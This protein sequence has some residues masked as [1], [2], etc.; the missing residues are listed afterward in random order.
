V[1]DPVDWPTRDLLTHRAAAT[2]ERTALVDA[3]AGRSWTYR[4]LSDRVDR[5]AADLVPPAA[6]RVG[7]LAG[8]RP[9]FVETHW[10]VRRRAATAVPL[11][12]ALTAAELE[13]QA[14]RADLDV[15][16]HGDDFAELAASVAPGGCT[17]RSLEGAPD[18]SER[19]GS[20]DEVTPAEFDRDDPAVV[21]FTSGTTGDPKG[22]V[23]TA[24]N[25]VASA[26]A[27]AFRLGVSPGDRWLVCLPTYHMGGLAPVV[28]STLYG[29]TAVLQREFDADATADVLRR[30]EV[31]GVSLVP[32]MLTRM[33]DAGWTPPDSL[34][35]V[36]LG[37]APTP[38][39]LVERCRAR[40]VPVY[41]TYG[42][43]ETAS[44]VATATPDQAFEHGDTVGQPLVFTEMT[45]VDD[46][47]DP[48]PAGERGELVVDGPTVSPGYLDDDAT[49]AAVGEHG[50]HTG[51]LGYR[52]GDGLLWVLGRLDDAI[53]TGGET[54]HPATVAD[55]VRE[56]PAVADAAVVGLPDEEWGERVAALV[57][58]DPAVAPEF[59]LDDVR[60]ATRGRLAGH[61][62]PKTWGVADELP[63][64]A[65]GTVDRAA[66]RARLD[67]VREDG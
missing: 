53:Q 52:D 7:L 23:L 34:R 18:P 20:P 41:P 61:Q 9:A 65:S 4:E 57:V 16:L 35:F 2:P 56:H 63:R 37:G 5:R 50:L 60:R 47:G 51:D 39:S 46:D 54:V 58:A 27:S 14:A 59:D 13:P 25:L 3:D 21:L 30:R 55:A 40:G 24:G 11:N 31:T 12:A 29:T 1:R 26:T 48:L 33:L 10:A 44:Q 62:A 22:V 42:M 36:L 67:A 45:V 38:E 17:V 8:T 6:E 19:D 49:A 28:R 32:T 43:T 64:T 15:L 66:V